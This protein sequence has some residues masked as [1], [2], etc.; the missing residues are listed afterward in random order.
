MLFSNSLIFIKID[1][2][3]LFPIKIKFQGN[4]DIVC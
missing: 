4:L 3:K 1:S 2:M